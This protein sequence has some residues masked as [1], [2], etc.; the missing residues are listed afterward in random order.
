M[1]SIV[2]LLRLMSVFDVWLSHTYVLTTFE[3]FV[4][5]IYKRT[6]EWL[7]Q[8]KSLVSIDVCIVMLNEIIAR[9]TWRLSMSM[10]NIAQWICTIDDDDSCI[11][12]GTII[13]ILRISYL[14]ERK[15]FCLAIDSIGISWIDMYHKNLLCAIVNMLNDIIIQHNLINQVDHRTTIKT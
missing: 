8:A 15:A 5:L 12:I 10:M 6:V 9:W 14:N 7:T 11:S 2:I 13:D 3:C 4:I 1:T